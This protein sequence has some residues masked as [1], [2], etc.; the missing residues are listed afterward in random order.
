[1]CKVF[2]ACSIFSAESQ[3]VVV[4]DIDVDETDEEDDEDDEDE[5]VELSEKMSSD[6]EKKSESLFLN[7]EIPAKEEVLDTGITAE[8]LI[9]SVVDVDDAV[10][11]E[12]VSI[13]VLI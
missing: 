9:I 3:I 8:N 10:D 7:A 12:N 13:N 11:D 5:G 4:A 6:A 1:M 2:A